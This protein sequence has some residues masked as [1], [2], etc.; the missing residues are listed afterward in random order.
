MPKSRTS[1]NFS[2]E[3]YIDE[4]SEKPK[5]AKFTYRISA[6]RLSQKFSIAPS[7]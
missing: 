3:Y 2:Y 1:E 4:T 5:K 7:R 6:N